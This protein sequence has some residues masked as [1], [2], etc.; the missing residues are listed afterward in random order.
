LWG[1]GQNDVW[2]TDGFGMVSHFDGSGWTTFET[3]EDYTAIFGLSSDE[4]WGVGDL[5][6]IGHFDGSDWSDD[7]LS[8]VEF[9][10][11][12]HG[13]PAGDVWVVGNDLRAGRG[14]VYRQDTGD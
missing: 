1:F 7:R 5:G 9:Y 2:A 3:E 11:A 8:N 6:V 4:L 14:V 12:V 13:S 10:G